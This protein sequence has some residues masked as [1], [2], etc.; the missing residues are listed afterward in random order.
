[1][2][3]SLEDVNGESSRTKA[4]TAYYRPSLA[5]IIALLRLKVQWFAQ[6]ERWGAFDHN[7]R[8]LGR[9]GLLATGV[10]ERLLESASR[11]RQASLMEGTRIKSSIDH[12]AQYLPV[13][14]TERLL[15]SYE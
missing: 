9:E 5:A 3:S 6:E 8:Q 14:I 13:S 7:I 2:P 10:D 11:D 1:V 15:K 12:F 4:G